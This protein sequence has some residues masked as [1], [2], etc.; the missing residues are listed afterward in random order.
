MP[1]FTSFWDQGCQIPVWHFAGL[2]P[3]ILGVIWSSTSV[4]HTAT[5]EQ[6]ETERLVGSPDAVRIGNNSLVGGKLRV[7]APA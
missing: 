5:Q 4:S 7:L 1:L 3:Q 2:I 6:K